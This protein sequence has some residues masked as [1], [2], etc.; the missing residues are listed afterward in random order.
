MRRRLLVFALLTITLVPS[1]AF[2][3]NDVGHMTVALLAYRKLAPDVKKNVDRMLAQH[4]AVQDFRAEKPEG[5]NDEGAWIFMMASTWPDAIKSVQN[6]YHDQFDPD[7]PHASGFH[8][9]VHDPEHF[10]DLPYVP[11]DDVDAPKPSGRTIVKAINDAIAALTA[12]ST[13]NPENAAKLSFLIHF[14]GDIHQPLHCATRFTA[15]DFPEGDRGGNEFMIRLSDV[16]GA[17][18]L[19]TFWD[20]LVGR[21][22]AHHNPDPEMISARADE[23]T[24]EVSGQLDAFKAIVRTPPETWADE[25]FRHAK[26]TAYLNNELNG[27]SRARFKQVHTAGVPTVQVG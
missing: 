22:T 10:I 12:D 3:W 6:K 21:T 4:P 27:V 1:A 17:M 24:D 7:D 23:V 2:A 13:P 25:S 19:H 26:E 18:V 20:D 8:R 16:S 9:G 14:L 11:D 5:F 15:D